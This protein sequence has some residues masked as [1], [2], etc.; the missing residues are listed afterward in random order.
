VSDLHIDGDRLLRR[1]D[2]LATIGPIEG[3]GSCRLA[4]T[5]EDRDGRDLVVA[6]MTDLGL[7][8]SMDGIGNVVGVRPGRTDG[9][10]IMTGSHI[11]TVRT[12]GRFDGNL[13]VLAGL[14]V[15]ETLEFNG[16]TTEHPFAVAFFTDEEG[17]RFQP[18]MLGSLV[19]AGGMGLE[20]ALDVVGIDGTVL[21]E[22]LDRIGYRGTS[23]CP[24]VAPR[25]FVELHV[26]QGP[27]L[28]ADGVTIGAV[29][30]VQGISWTELA[31]TGQSN[32]AGTTPMHLRHDAGYV[33]AAIAAHV[34]QLAI[35]MGGG[36][37]ATVGSLEL[38]PNLVNVVAGSATMTVDLRNTDEA[39]LVEAEADLARFVAEVAAA[40]GVTVAERTLARF[41]PVEFDDRVVDTV[42]AV[43]A[44]LGHSVKRLPS[45]AG[46]D[47]QM[48]ARLCPTGMVFVPSRDGI[49][50]NPAEYT[51]PDDL[52]AGADVLL[53]SMLALD[54][55][56]L[57]MN[58]APQGRDVAS[59]DAAGGTR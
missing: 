22:E 15:I 43:A 7:D 58:S 27:V 28:E 59:T 3:G 48:M 29:T 39:L 9:P 50:H 4:L 2:D 17:A 13:G 20:E 49:S 38:N 53:G 18:D 31:I 11:D 47:A 23:P 55:M 56:D 16:I 21:G 25:A 52:V 1:I 12:G 57:S 32:H 19:Y 10:P 26:E 34:R 41:Q 45:G 42:A 40:E 14:E 37:V 46:H 44:E 35:R 8:I 36:Q 24:G 51:E 33:A 5:D 54:A 30:G 6:W